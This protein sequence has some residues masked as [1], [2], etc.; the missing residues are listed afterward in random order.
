MDKGAGLVLK[1]TWIPLLIVVVLVLG[2]L[3]VCRV[4]GF[5]GSNTEI[6]RPGAGLADDAEP[7][8]PKTVTYEVFGKEGAVATINYLDLQANPQIVRDVPLPWSVKLTT[9]APSASATVVA[10]GDGDSI[11]CRVI[12]NDEI[13]A[14]NTSDGVSAQTFCL[15]KSA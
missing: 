3:V 15:V 12:V 4:R 9:K 5:F 2:G 13:K 11:S 7:F 8:N 14:E 1:R 6:T 10:Q